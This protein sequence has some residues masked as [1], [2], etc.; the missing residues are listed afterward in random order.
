[1]ILLN[2]C[3]RLFFIACT[4]MICSSLSHAQTDEDVAKALLAEMAEDSL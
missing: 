2:R 4:V 3:A 1:M